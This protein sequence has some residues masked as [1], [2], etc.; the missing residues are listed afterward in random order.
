MVAHPRAAGGPD[1]VRPL[2]RPRPVRVEADGQGQP[3][4]VYLSN[5]RYAVEAVLETWRIDH[6]WWRERPVSRIYFSVLLEDGRTVTV[7]RDLV[8]QQWMKQTYRFVE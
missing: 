3:T 8:S 6:E 7:Y 2:N 4:A 5:H 1:R